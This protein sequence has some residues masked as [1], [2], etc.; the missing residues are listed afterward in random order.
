MS[1][2]NVEVVRKLFST[3]ERNE[4]EALL[5]LF[6]EDVEWSPVEGK[7]HGIEGVGAAWVDWMESWDQHR[8]EPEEFIESGE[9]RVLAVIRLTARGEGSGMEIDQRFFQVYTVREGKIV[10]MVEYVDRS[11]ALEAAGLSE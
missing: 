1:E 9:D 6:D 7:Y 3:L 5:E 10:R 11:P 8:I 4:A 2:E